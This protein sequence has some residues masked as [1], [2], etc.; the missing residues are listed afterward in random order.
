LAAEG[1][2]RA[3]QA[4]ERAKWAAQR[5]RDLA[6]WIRGAAKDLTDLT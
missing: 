1:D 2:P 6:A 5:A 3:K 4:G